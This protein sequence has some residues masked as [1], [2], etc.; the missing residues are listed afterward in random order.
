MK[1]EQTGKKAG[2]KGEETRR[3]KVLT[4]QYLNQQK[5]KRQNKNLRI[6]QEP[7]PVMVIWHLSACA[8]HFHSKSVFA[9]TM[10]IPLPLSTTW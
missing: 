1:D 6:M 4:R 2:G 5:I 9:L 3:E 10:G 8:L 7:R